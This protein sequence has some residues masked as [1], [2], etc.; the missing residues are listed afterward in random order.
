MVIHIDHGIFYSDEG[1]NLQLIQ[2]FNYQAE[3]LKKQLDSH[4]SSNLER[5]R[6]EAYNEGWKD[7]KAKV[8]KKTWFAGWW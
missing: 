4:L 2:E 8:K 5:I 3:L 7:A 6:R 1:F